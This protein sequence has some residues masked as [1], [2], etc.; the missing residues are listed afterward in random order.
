VSGGGCSQTKKDPNANAAPL[1]PSGLPPGKKNRP[2]TEIW[3]VGFF[4]AELDTYLDLKQEANR[5]LGR[6][7]TWMYLV[8]LI[9]AFLDTLSNYL[10]IAPSATF[11]VETLSFQ[12]ESPSIIPILFSPLIALFIL[13][14]WLLIAAFQEGLVKFFGGW[15]K[16]E[17]YVFLSAAYA[18]PLTIIL[19]IVGFIPNFIYLVCGGLIFI[20][21][22]ILGPIAVK[23]AYEGL[24]WGQ[25]TAAY[26]LPYTPIVLCMCVLLSSAG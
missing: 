11:Q 13:G 17:D 9:G 2:W 14:G 21:Q 10:F 5:E 15:G 12:E 19:G 26:F 18:A 24:G 8:F 25:A 20:Y 1:P 4:E 23:A 22:A 6:S 7:L 16:Y 3:F